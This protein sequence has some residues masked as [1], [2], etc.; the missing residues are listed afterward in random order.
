MLFVL[1]FELIT[2]ASGAVNNA[3]SK[4]YDNKV[5]SSLY[6][7]RERKKRGTRIVQIILSLLNIIAVEVVS[8]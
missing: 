4:P 6:G 1:I 7:V 3:S 5:S 8:R 2:L